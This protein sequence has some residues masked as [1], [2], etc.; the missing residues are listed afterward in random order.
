MEAERNASPLTVR[1]YRADLYEFADFC[2]E[3]EEL[4]DMEEVDIKDITEGHVRAYIRMLRQERDL[5]K[6]SISRHMGSLHSFYKFLLREHIVEE[7]PTRFLPMPK[8]EQ[9]LPRFLYYEEM[10]AVLDAPDDSL[11]GRRDRGIL[12]LLYA[13][14]IRVAEAAALDI[15]D[16]DRE[17]GYVRVM[18]KGGR[19]RLQ[20]LAG[21]AILVLDNYLEARRQ[22]GQVVGN[23]EPLFL[24]HRGQRLSDRSYR[25]ILDKYVREAAIIK[26]ISPHAIR[27]TFATHLLENGADIRA[28][29]ELL[30]HQDIGTTQIY[31]H[32]GISKIKEVYN[33]TH[34]RSGK[35]GD[36]LEEE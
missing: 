23:A 4:E 35:A 19:E 34:P 2:A 22:T 28:V 24:N 18:G 7:N 32:V 13:T 27:H 36:K 10:E 16:I 1:Y 31:T 8:R 5:K 30:G 17:R 14:G 11:L 6:S 21:E 20:P 3:L 25:N 15:G 29:Q 26:K 12:E 33:Q 9:R